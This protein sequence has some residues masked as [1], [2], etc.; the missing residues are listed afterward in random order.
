MDLVE[1]DQRL[2]FP[3]RRPLSERHGDEAHGAQIVGSHMSA[4]LPRMWLRF[5]VLRNTSRVYR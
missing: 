5:R 4:T 1:I 2:L 3:E